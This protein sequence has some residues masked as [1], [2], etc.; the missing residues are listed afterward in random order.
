MMVLSIDSK[1][2]SNLICFQCMFPIYILPLYL[3]ILFNPSIYEQKKYV[4]RFAQTIDLEITFF[5]SFEIAVR[6][7]QQFSIDLPTG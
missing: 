6:V 7:S 1:N 2:V 3:Y 5:E 4:G